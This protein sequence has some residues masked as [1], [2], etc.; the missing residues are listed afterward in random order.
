MSELYCAPNIESIDSVFT[1]FSLIELQEIAS[2]LNGY[3][4]VQGKPRGK[5]CKKKNKCILLSEINN[6]EL[7]SKYELYEAISNELGALCKTESCWTTLDF[8][9]KIKDKGVRAKLMYYTFKPETTKKDASWLAT[10]NINEIMY[11]YELKYNKN[12]K[13]TFRFMGAVPSDVI[14]V[15]KI[16]WV[17]LKEYKYIGIVFNNDTHTKSGTHWTSMYINNKLKSVECFDSLGKLP[18]K[19]IRTFIKKWAGYKVTTSK[20]VHQR[21]DNLC[22]V[23]ACYF[24]I[25]RLEGKTYNEINA[26]I[27]TDDFMSGCK[28]EYFRPRE[29]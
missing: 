7:L 18:N 27:I 19:H 15:S 5:V 9:K 24:L 12:E 25:Q 23:Y 1:C 26:N 13:D 10:D 2:A 17:K 29:T 14:K 20:I 3:I 6:V 11:Q 16:D 8:I 4:A 22:G 21:G 28:K